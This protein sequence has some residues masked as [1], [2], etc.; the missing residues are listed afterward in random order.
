MKKNWAASYDVLA[1]AVCVAFLALVAQQAIAQQPSTQGQQGVEE[2]TVTGTR[3]ITSGVNTPTPVTSVSGV[4]LQKMSPST[5]IESLSQLPV[6]DNNLA[7]QQAVGGAVAPGGS[8]LN[9]R[10]LDAPRT[11]VLLDGRRLGPSNKFGTVDVGVIPET[12]VR[13]VEAVTPV[14]STFAWTGNSPASKPPFKSE[15]RPIA[16]T[17]LIKWVS[18]TVPT[19]ANAG[20]SSRQP[21]SG[22]KTASAPSRLYRTA[23]TS[24]IS[25]PRSRIRTPMGRTS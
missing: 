12:L 1:Q 15:P 3:L 5:L 25:R 11:L 19:S 18:D 14:S 2:V 16:T 7:S 6:F 10:G 22:T 8:N 24:I 4:D 9:L 23:P 17:I 21:R 13:S 20:T